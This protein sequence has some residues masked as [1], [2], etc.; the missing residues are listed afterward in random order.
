MTYW[1]ILMIT[2][3][4]EPQDGAMTGL[5]YRSEAECIAAH[6]IVSATLGDAYDY[7]IACVPTDTPSGSVRPKARPLAHGEG[8]A[9]G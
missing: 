2:I 1:T 5:L 3:L 6:Q 4:G 9:N 8:D 7:Q